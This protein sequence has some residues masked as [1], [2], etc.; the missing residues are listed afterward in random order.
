[1]NVDQ[2][3]LLQGLPPGVF[4]RDHVSGLLPSYEYIENNEMSKM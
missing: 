2:L 1:M 4:L 3:E